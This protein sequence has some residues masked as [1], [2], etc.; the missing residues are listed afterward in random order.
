M[1]PF[2]YAISASPSVVAVGVVATGVVSA[3]AI[4]VGVV[5]AG[6]VSAVVESGDNNENIVVS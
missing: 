1:N 4:S 2:T 3:G 6:D 5:S